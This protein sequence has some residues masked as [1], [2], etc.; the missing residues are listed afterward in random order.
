MEQAAGSEVG[1]E[2]DIKFRPGLGGKRTGS[3]RRRVHEEGKQQCLWLG[4]GP[5]AQSVLQRFKEL[6][7]RAGFKQHKAFLSH[8]LATHNRYPK[9]IVV[10][11]TMSCRLV[12]VQVQW[13]DGIRALLTTPSLAGQP[14]SHTN[15]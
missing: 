4:T 13:S 15:E 10:L 14:H 9:F 6:E 8:L 11:L 12:R 5:E 3:G 7:R 2:I 1:S